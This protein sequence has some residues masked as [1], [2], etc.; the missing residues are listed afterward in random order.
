MKTL[1]S[2]PES[3]EELVFK[4]RNREYGAYLLRKS[5][6]QTVFIAT[7]ITLFVFSIPVSLHD[8]EQGNQRG[9]Y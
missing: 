4:N 5:Y 9:R 2:P 3:F 8:H 7:L 1:K 6:S